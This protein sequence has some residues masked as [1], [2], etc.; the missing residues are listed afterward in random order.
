MPTTPPHKAKAYSLAN[1]EFDN[2]RVRLHAIEN[3]TNEEVVKAL[4]NYKDIG[5][6]LRNTLTS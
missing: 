4:D 3:P 1:D 2:L 5:A 6:R